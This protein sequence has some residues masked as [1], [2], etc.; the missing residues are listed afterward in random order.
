MSAKIRLFRRER[1]CLWH[2]AE[3]IVVV[4]GAVVVVVGLVRGCM[5]GV[6][7]AECEEN[8]GMCKNPFLRL[9]TGIRREWTVL[10]ED[11]R[12]AATPFPCGKCMPCMINRARVTKYRILFESMTHQANAFITL[13]YSDEKIP[14]GGNLSHQDFTNFMKRLRNRIPRK[15]RFYGVGEYG[16]KTWRPHYHYMLFN[17]HMTEEETIKDAWRDRD[18]QM[19][20]HI[21]VGDVSND[22]AGYVSGY[23]TDKFSMQTDPRMKG[24]V[25]PF[26]RSSR[27]NGGIGYP[28]IKIMAENMK[29][30]G[31]RPPGTVRETKYEGKMV[32]LGRYCMDKL[33]EMSGVTEYEKSLELYEYQE[34]IFEK[35]LTGKGI[36]KENIIEEKSQERIRQKRRKQI[37]DSRRSL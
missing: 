10:S 6:S 22:S 17:V 32:P 26:A 27:R 34:E 35:F 7:V 14:K 4:V 18:G 31:Y 8:V 28:A 21:K 2:I 15:I 1:R 11:A 24:L 37:S 13:T 36:Y 29:K 20:G 12:L 9:P 3:A 5:R 16:R 19:I 23:V 30:R 33:K 25:Q